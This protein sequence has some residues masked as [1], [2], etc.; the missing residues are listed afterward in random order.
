MWDWK[1]I[2]SGTDLIFGAGLV[3]LFLVAPAAVDFV[4]VLLIPPPL[5]LP[6]PADPLFAVAVAAAAEAL[7]RLMS[8]CSLLDSEMR[9]GGAVGFDL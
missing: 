1:W 9:D 8:A 7:D 3:G 5:P 6:L 4:L 2:D